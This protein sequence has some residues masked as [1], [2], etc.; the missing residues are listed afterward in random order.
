MSH[1]LLPLGIVASPWDRPRG[2][3]AIPWPSFRGKAKLLGRTPDGRVTVYTRAQPGSGTLQNA[4]D[5]LADAPR[6]VA[7]ND[8]IFGTKSGKVNVIVFNLGGSVNGGGGADHMACNYKAG[9]NI[10]VDADVGDSA[11]V[12]ALFEAELS[13]C[14]MNGR[15][16]GLSTGEGLSRWCAMETSNNAILPEYLSAPVWFKDGAANWVDQTDRSDRNYDSTGCTM[17]NL[18]WL[19][20][21]GHPLSKI[22][23]AMVK[24][25]DGGTLAALYAAL[26]GDAASNAWPK[27]KAAVSGISGGVVNDD[28]FG[29]FGKPVSGTKMALGPLASQ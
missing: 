27:F 19:Q 23:Q 13:E 12:G 8:A 26:T 3:G 10:E 5:L 2:T 11:F 18:S 25:G 20:F 21:L 14:S 29:V 17:A 7:A 22:A 16:C 28:P 9:Q 15:L 1:P 6:I 4:V 24:L